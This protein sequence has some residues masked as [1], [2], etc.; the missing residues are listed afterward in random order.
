MVDGSTSMRIRLLP[1]THEMVSNPYYFTIL[2]THCTKP[3]ESSN[4]EQVILRLHKK[5]HDEMGYKITKR[6][7]KTLVQTAIKMGL[8][9]N[10]LHWDARGHVIYNVSSSEA[11]PS[12]AEKIA[13]LKYFLDIDG[14][15]IIQLMNELNRKSGI[16]KAQFMKNNHVERLFQD[17]ATIYLSKTSDVK[18]R[19]FLLNLLRNAERGYSPHYRQHKI[20]PRM[21]ILSNLGLIEITKNGQECYKPKIVY[22]KEKE[23]NLVQLFLENFSSVDTLD[24]ILG[25]DG[26]FFKR[27]AKLYLITA[28]SVDLNADLELIA[29][30]VVNAY[31]C[32]KDK[33]FGLASLEAIRDIV[34]LILLTKHSKICEWKHVDKV[35]ENMRKIYEKNVR[36]HVDDW[37]VIKYIKIDEK[38][39]KKYI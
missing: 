7:C 39:V 3:R 9:F 30:E 24:Q 29:K 5:L 36:Y 15:V 21:H 18:E 26:D 14:A 34:C 19:H 22:A 1:E 31:N 11:G 12:Q 33:T 17:I 13:Y 25:K 2:I 32:V 38:I 6:A 28:D 23:I 4:E 37:G 27:A 10:D 16:F 20:T 8:V 35:I